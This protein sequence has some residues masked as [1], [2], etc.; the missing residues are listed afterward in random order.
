M[1]FNPP[2]CSCCS[3]LRS[4]HVVQSSEVF[5]LFNPPECSCCSFLRS[6]H[7]VQSSGVLMLFNPPSVHVVQSL[8][9]CVVLCRSLVVILTLFIS[10]LY[11]LSFFNIRLLI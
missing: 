9:F 4:V 6:V 10:V 11:C 8:V 7:V 3:I 5:M 2:E 1:F